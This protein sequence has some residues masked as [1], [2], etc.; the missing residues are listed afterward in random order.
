MD[1]V[2]LLE[3]EWETPRKRRH[4]RRSHGKGHHRKESDGREADRGAGR[5]AGGTPVSGESADV[6]LL[7]GVADSEEAGSLV[8]LSD[9]SQ[10]LSTRR[11]AEGFGLGGTDG[12]LGAQDFQSQNAGVS[13]EE[14]SVASNSDVEFSSVST[15]HANEDVTS[16]H[17]QAFVGRNPGLASSSYCE[18]FPMSF[19]DLAS[20]GES[21]GR[22][23]SYISRS[24]WLLPV[25]PLLP[26]LLTA[27]LL[28]LWPILIGWALVSCKYTYM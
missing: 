26:C 14:N 7:E 5:V 28:L 11:T 3:E 10:S 16:E 22:L 25:L 6:S 18:H 17:S 27:A 8:G 19:L 1:L 13:Q 12:F 20:I 9:A 15:I 2:S 21:I 24:Y 4:T 23:S